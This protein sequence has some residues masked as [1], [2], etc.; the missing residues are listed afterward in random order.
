M[1]KIYAICIIA[2]LVFLCG[3]EQSDN[4]DTTVSPETYPT[5]ITEPVEKQTVLPQEYED[6]LRQYEII[7]SSWSS[8][9]AEEGY[10]NFTADY[11]SGRL[12][13][14]NGAENYEW[15]NMLIEG[16]YPKNLR[17]GYILKDISGDAVP[18]MFWVCEDYRILAAFT[19]VN[20]QA[21]T[22]GAYYPKYKAMVLDSNEIFVHATG[23]ASA[24]EVM[25]MSLPAGAYRLE[26]IIHVTYYNG[27]YCKV[28]G[29]KETVI[30]KAEFDLFVQQYPF[31]K[32]PTLKW[33]ENPI[34]YVEPG[35][36]GD[37]SL[38]S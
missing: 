2:L 30:S 3:C 9:N 32:E 1:K 37:G 17:Y 21:V 33:K 4:P 27:T 12:P 14:P 35:G 11:E 16:K 18:E 6:I 20:G 29:E 19:I 5:A 26:S 13:Y 22:I 31:I 23:G 7:V 38:V 15:N 36:Q 24:G 28:V 34:Y 25:I 8:D 10:P